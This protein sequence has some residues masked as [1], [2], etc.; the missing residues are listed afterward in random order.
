MGKAK[1]EKDLKSK[2]KTHDRNTKRIAVNIYYDER[3]SAQ[4]ALLVQQDVF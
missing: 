3:D 1:T 2:N 4:P